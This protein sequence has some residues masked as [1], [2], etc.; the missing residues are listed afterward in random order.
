M[1]D[2]ALR[3]DGLVLV[4]GGGGFIGSNIALALAAEGRDVVICDDLGTDGRWLNLREGR[5]HD[6]IAI[7]ALSDWIARNGTALAGV[8]H[9]GAISATTETD[10]DLIVR[11]NI[12]ATLDLWECCTRLGIPFVYASS[13]ATYG[14]GTRGFEDADTAEALAQLRPLNAYGWSKH[15]VD[16]RLVHDRDT[17]RPTPPSWAGLKF[18]NVYGPRESHKG[19]MRS[20]IHQIR[21]GAERGEPVRLFRSD[22]P[23]YGDGGQLRDFVHVDDCVRFA[24][25]ALKTPGLGGIFN[26]GTGQARSFEDLARATFAAVEREPVIEYIDMPEALRGRYQYFT[27]AR[28]ERGVAAGLAPNWRS[29]EAGVADYVGWLRDNP[30]F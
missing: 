6:V 27:E 7:D 3:A 10:V 28:T 15:M 13:A 19:S 25:A 16:R 29:L 17:G 30:D 12:R 8:V 9:M 11:L 26:V 4:T 22:N 5:F 1:T 21:P 2:S 20:V 23:D 24:I 18:F 14:D